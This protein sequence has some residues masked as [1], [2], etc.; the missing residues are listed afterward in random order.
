MKKIITILLIGAM[1]T[2]F[3]SCGEKP[4]K[5]ENSTTVNTEEKLE[6]IEE[7]DE[8]ED[9]KENEDAE[10]A[11]V[12]EGEKLSEENAAEDKT[13]K[14]PQTQ[15]QS[16]PSDTKPQ[17]TAKPVETK[18]QEENNS[19]AKPAPT[20][21]PVESTP[22]PTP[23]PVVN[24][25]TD[26]LIGYM[27]SITKGATDHLKMAENIPVDKDMFSYFTFTDY[28]EGAV[29]VA[30]ESAIGSQAH[31]VVLIWLPNKSD[32][33]T[34]AADIQKNMDPRKWICVEAEKSY[35]KTK[36]NFV[37]LVMT[38]EDAANKIESNFSAL[39]L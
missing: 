20:E 5:E 1:I 7:I 30:N 37:L 28:I 27:N 3:A 11:E 18:P 14:K 15:T 6:H 21:K 19:T 22:A 31:S 4:A 26:D 39:S 32:V 29:A 25:T 16:K 8:A 12:E 23:A 24:K 9:A 34:V 2:S 13:E 10:N 33:A 36:G 38:N 17:T 35:V